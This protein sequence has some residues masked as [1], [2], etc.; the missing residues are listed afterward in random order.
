MFPYYKM[1]AYHVSENHPYRSTF[2]QA[3]SDGISPQFILMFS[4]IYVLGTNLK[5]SI[6]FP[7]INLVN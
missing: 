5:D 1:A 2:G 7:S 4:P 6:H 3:A